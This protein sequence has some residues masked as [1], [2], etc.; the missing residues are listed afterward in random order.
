MLKVEGVLLCRT[1][2]AK[3]STDLSIEEVREFK[4]LC[5]HAQS[6]LTVCSV[7]VF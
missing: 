5:M 6:C 3:V 2:T 1:W 4:S 7:F